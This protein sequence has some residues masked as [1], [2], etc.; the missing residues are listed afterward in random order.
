M[1]STH[2]L[3]LSFEELGDFIC[4]LKYFWYLCDAVPLQ[5]ERRAV[6]VKIKPEYC[7]E[8]LTV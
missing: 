2:R 8:S 1:S 4:P 6:Q 5:K 7:L 3:Q